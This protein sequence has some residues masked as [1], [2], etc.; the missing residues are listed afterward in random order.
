MVPQQTTVVKWWALEGKKGENL[1]GA[2]RHLELPLI[3]GCSQ[4]KGAHFWSLVTAFT[5]LHWVRKENGGM[6]NSVDRK[7]W[8]FWP[9]LS[10]PTKSARHYQVNL[11][12]TLILSCNFL[13]KTF[14]NIL[15]STLY[16]IPSSFTWYLRPSLKCFITT[17][18]FSFFD[19][20][21]YLYLLSTCLV[22]TLGVQMVNIHYPIPLGSLFVVLFFSVTLHLR[23][24]FLTS[25]HH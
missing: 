6:N 14:I 4:W 18:H 17:V 7:W 9:F 23:P 13:P 10:V 11:S 1:A 22:Q 15:L 24:L 20:S 21:S 5:S 2:C 3:R 8:S 19:V 16:N 25:S 12:K